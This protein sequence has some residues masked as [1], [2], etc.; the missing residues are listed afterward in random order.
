MP[1]LFSYGTLQLPDVQQAIFSRRISGAPDELPSYELGKVM[2]EDP[3]EAQALRRTYYD[4]VVFTGRPNDRVRGTVM[5]VTDAELAA[6]DRYEE[7]AGYRRRVV[8]LGSGAEAWAYSCD[9]TN[10]TSE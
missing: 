7:P 10:P 8:T 3:Q 5:E 4:N 2:I 9:R 1:F 6:A